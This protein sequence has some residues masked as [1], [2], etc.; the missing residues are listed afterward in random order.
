MY[1]IVYEVRNRPAWVDIPLAAVERLA[2]GFQQNADAPQ[3]QA[4]QEDTP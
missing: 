2:S 1:E 4:H 3:S